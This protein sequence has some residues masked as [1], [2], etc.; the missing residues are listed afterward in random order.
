MTRGKEILSTTELEQIGRR[1]EQALQAGRLDPVLVRDRIEDCFVAIYLLRHREGRLVFEIP[2]PTN[3]HG[4]I[5]EVSDPS[6][7]VGEIRKRFRDFFVYLG[8][9]WERPTRQSLAT[10]VAELSGLWFGAR[11][12]AQV[13]GDPLLTEH[14]NTCQALLERIRTE[15]ERIGGPE[16]PEEKVSEETKREG[17]DLRRG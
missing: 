7:L 16:E 12:L 9:S 1:I 6:L 11:E 8:A 2:D 13:K 15:G 4:I 5:T 14:F 10:I 3:R 17:A